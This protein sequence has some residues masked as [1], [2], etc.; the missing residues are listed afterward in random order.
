MAP[1]VVRIPVEA[2]LEMERRINAWL[3]LPLRI[4]QERVSRLRRIGD[5]S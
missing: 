5:M 4:R 1:R 3:E 2:D